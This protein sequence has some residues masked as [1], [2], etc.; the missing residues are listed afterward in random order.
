M[1]IPADR[2]RLLRWTELPDPPSHR[3]P[4]YMTQRRTVEIID[5]GLEK[6]LA[7]NKFTHV[8]AFNPV[9]F[10]LTNCS[11]LQASVQHF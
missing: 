7:D 4:P 9:S 3:L 5:L 1:S 2:P 10:L 6:I 8:Q 11:Y